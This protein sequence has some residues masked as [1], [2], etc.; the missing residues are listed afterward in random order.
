VNDFKSSMAKYFWF[1]GLMAKT[2][3]RL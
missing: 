2:K 1:C 3:L